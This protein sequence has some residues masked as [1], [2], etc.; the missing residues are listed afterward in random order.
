MHAP[1]DTHTQRHMNRQVLAITSTGRPVTSGVSMYGC[2]RNNNV[3]SYADLY[4][5]LQ[6]QY[7][8]WCTA[9]SPDHEQHI[10]CN[11]NIIDCHV[12]VCM[13]LWH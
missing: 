1:T 8:Y 10:P 11:Y 4:H 5:C 13:F 6:P 3:I 7:S 9:V 2:V 12:H